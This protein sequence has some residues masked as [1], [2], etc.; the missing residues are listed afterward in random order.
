ME[1]VYELLD[2]LP[3]EDI[4]VNDYVRPLINSAQVTYEKGEYQFSYFAVHLIFMTNIYTTVW[5]VSQFYKERYNHSLLFARPYNGK[6]VKLDEIS[7]VFEFSKL[8]EKDIFEFF[9]LIGLDDSYVKSTKKLIDY[10]NEMAH[11]TGKIQISSKDD[12]DDAVNG[13]ISVM[14]NIHEKFSITIKSF[15][16]KELR[17]YAKTELEEFF[18][19]PDEYVDFLF[20]SNLHFSPNELLVCKEF[21]L[22]KLK[23]RKKSGL[24]LEEVRRIVE[25]HTSINDKYLEK[26]G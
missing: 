16:E 26:V 25:F 6:E 12:F 20:I 10:R 23:N 14:R 18:A 22:N 15:Y 7:S 4:E 5:Q 19:S 24:S 17:E 11:A 2:Y 8:P 21:G 13:I 9:R 3:L 1:N